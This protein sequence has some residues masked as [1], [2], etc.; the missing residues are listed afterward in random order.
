M[1]SSA[2]TETE[3]MEA[4][5]LVET[6]AAFKESPEEFCEVVDSATWRAMISAGRAYVDKRLK[7]LGIC[8]REEMNDE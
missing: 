8:E 5:A 7:E 2:M 6:K 1:E 3:V 4:A